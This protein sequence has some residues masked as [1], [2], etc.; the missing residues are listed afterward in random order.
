MFLLLYLP[1]WGL[2]PLTAILYCPLPLMERITAAIFCS[3]GW[4]SIKTNS[5]HTS[6]FFWH[7]SGLLAALHMPCFLS[8]SFY[9]L[10]WNTAEHLTTIWMLLCLPAYLRGI[11]LSPPLPFV[12]SHTNLCSSFLLLCNITCSL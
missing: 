6:A 9:S 11:C 3:H 5:L 4:E 7:Y 1:A 10:P 12:L 8:P 2:S